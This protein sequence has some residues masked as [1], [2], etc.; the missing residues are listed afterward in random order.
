MLVTLDT[1]VLQPHFFRVSPPLAIK[2]GENKKRISHR[3]SF[4]ESAMYGQ[5]RFWS[6][7]PC[8]TCSSPVYTTTAPLGSAKAFTVLG[9]STTAKDHLTPS[10]A[11]L[12][13]ASP[14][15]SLAART[16]RFATP[17]SRRDA[18]WP[19]GSSRLRA[20]AC[21]SICRKVAS[22]SA[23]SCARLSSISRLRPVICDTS[24]HA[25]YPPPT[26]AAASAPYGAYRARELCER[27]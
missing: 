8:L 2:K 23:R 21:R 13:P 7:T 24:E 20:P 16:T 17:C 3:C 19:V 12:W 25:R 10:S 18:A 27:C 6:S 4:A 15:R 9:S 26:R 1:R 5:T 11:P 14:S 22:P